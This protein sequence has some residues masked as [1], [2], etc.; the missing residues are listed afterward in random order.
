MDLVSLS[1]LRARAQRAADQENSNFIS[2]AEW[3]DYINHGLRRMHDLIVS[4]S[5]DEYCLKSYNFTLVANTS[6]YALPTDFFRERAFDL[7]TAPKPVTM[8]RFNFRERNKYNW[9]QFSWGAVGGAPLFCIV[10][11]NVMFMP[12]PTIASAG[13]TMWYTPTLQKTSDNG[14][15][16]TSGT[17]S[18]DTDQID[19]INGYEELAVIHAAILAKQKEDTDASL[20]MARLAQVENWVSES[21]RRRNDGDPVFVQEVQPDGAGFFGF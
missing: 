3:Q 8:Q 5:G 16:W 19:G 14:V 12:A 11:Q 6:T 1:T 15:T 17:L 7:N 4:A 10:G 20:L 21:C 9:A 18:S 13:I 2:T